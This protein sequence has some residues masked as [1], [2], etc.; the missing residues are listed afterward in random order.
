MRKLH[1]ILCVA[2]LICTMS[3]TSCL[4]AAK[5]EYRV[6]SATFATVTR[7]ESGAYRLFLDQGRGIVDPSA[8]GT[9]VNWGDA[10]RVYLYYDIPFVD[11]LYD[12][13]RY[14][15]IVRDAWKIDTTRFVDVTGLSEFPKALG[16]DTL[17]Y[18]DFQAYWG[19]LTIM[20]S[21]GNKE[22]FHMTCSYDRNEFKGDT[23]YLNL[24]Y[25]RREG[26]WGMSLPQTVCAEIPEFVRNS[27][28]SDSLC[29]AMSAPCWYSTAADSVVTRTN[30]FKISKRRLVPPT[31]DGIGF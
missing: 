3:F 8:N 23:L 9:E 28:A 4:D 26:T 21:P 2:A 15:T 7:S 1:V 12:Y 17:Y 16:N 13:T 24:H 22:N 29:I 10:Q 11:T 19:F 18:F 6:T 20:A 30:Y 31:Y 5:N 25:A 14:R 27:V